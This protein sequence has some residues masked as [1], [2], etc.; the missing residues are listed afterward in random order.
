[1]KILY[2]YIYIKM[3]YIYILSALAI[4][5]VFFLYNY[6]FYLSTIEDYEREQA[7]KNSIKDSFVLFVLS[8]GTHYLI[9][10]YFYIDF[11]NK[12]FPSQPTKKTAEIFTDQPGF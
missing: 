12:I 2:K 5:V 4:S 11:V 1:M 6:I 9:Q 8:C 10:E 7:F 3:M